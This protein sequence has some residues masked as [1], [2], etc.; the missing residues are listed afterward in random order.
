MG[1][2]WEIE[3]EILDCCVCVEIEELDQG[4]HSS[5][6]VNEGRATINRHTHTHTLTHT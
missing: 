3:I 5:C 6:K 2:L 4:K 1:T